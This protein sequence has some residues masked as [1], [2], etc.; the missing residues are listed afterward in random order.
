V[1][2]SVWGY[3]PG[4]RKLCNGAAQLLGD[5]GEVA[6]LLE[7]GLAL[8]ALKSL[9]GALEEALVG[10]ETAVLGDAVV[11]F[12]SEKARGE[13][14]PDGGTVLV[15]VVEGSVLNLETLTVEGVVLRLLGDGSDKVVPRNAVSRVLRVA[16]LE[17]QDATHFS[18]I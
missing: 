1:Y 13:R 6:D 11:V 5:L 9:D 14:R 18:A 10:G 12:A 16:T 8:L 3:I 15:L 2:W 17:R 7:L 4:K